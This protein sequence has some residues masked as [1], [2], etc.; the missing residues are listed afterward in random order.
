MRF[1]R[2]DGGR[3]VHALAEIGELIESGRFLLPGV[4]TVPLEHVAEAHPVGE[5]GLV[6]GKM[7]LLVG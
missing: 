3:A 1:S 7:V 5:G 4:Q 2:C 6:R